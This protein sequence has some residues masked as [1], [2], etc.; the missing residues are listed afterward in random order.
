MHSVNLRLHSLVACFSA[1]QFSL[2]VW[3]PIRIYFFLQKLAT[4]FWTYRNSPLTLFWTLVPCNLH[5]FWILLLFT[6]P[7]GA[8]ASQESA[9]SQEL[10]LKYLEFIALIYSPVR[11]FSSHI[12][13]P[14][15]CKLPKAP[16][17]CSLACYFL[18]QLAAER[19]NKCKLFVIFSIFIKIFVLFHK[20]MCFFLLYFHQGLIHIFF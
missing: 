19:A 17:L 13:I 18:S 7:I 20:S 5:C 9:L 15:P 10:L 6:I 11:W 1:Q 3:L 12:Y 4:I 14:I 16:G 2:N 8:A